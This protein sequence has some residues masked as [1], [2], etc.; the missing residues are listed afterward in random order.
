MWDSLEH[1]YW[2]DTH[3]ESH[4]SHRY[5]ASPEHTSHSPLANNRFSVLSTDS[6]PLLDAPSL[7]KLITIAGG[8]VY[9]GLPIRG[10]EKNPVDLG[11]F[12]HWIVFPDRDDLINWIT[13]KMK[14][15]DDR[16]IIRELFD[17]M[18]EGVRVVLA[19]VSDL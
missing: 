11:A 7:A 10:T 9:E 19:K 18:S 6:I 4:L 15:Y 8:T 5:A 17:M 2:V 13:I 16:Q 12:P 14:R 3:S 1:G